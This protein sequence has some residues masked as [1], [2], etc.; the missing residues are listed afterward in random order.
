M[1]AIPGLHHVTAVCGPPKANVD[2]YTGRLRQR[3]IKKTVNFDDPTTYHLYYGTQ[4]AASASILTFFP[5]PDTRPGRAGA[6]MAGAFAYAV[7]SL[8]E[9]GDGERTER[10]GEPV[11]ILHDPDGLQVELVETGGDHGRFHGVTLLERDP[12]PTARVLSDLFGYE[13]VGQEGDRMRFRAADG[14]AR[15]VDIVRTDERGVPGAG[16]IH[17]VAF[18]ARDEAEHKN[19]R[20]RVAA[21]GHDITPVIDRQYFD[22]LYFREPGGVLFE[23]ATDTRG[24]AYDE[25][26][27]TMG[28]RLMLPPQYEPH[29]AEIERALP[30][31]G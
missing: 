30:P 9:W 31:L 16:T 27:D 20:E 17:H 4:D 15:V 23:I 2:F 1:T 12:E 25:P 26:A 7:E 24:F 3:L 13:A 10:F 21:A 29:R 11:L 5:F 19:W 8:A 28:E 14:P 22:A 6:G 18:R